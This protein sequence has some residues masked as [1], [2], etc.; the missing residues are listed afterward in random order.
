MET[1][2]HEQFS[3]DYMNRRK[4]CR[5]CCEELEWDAEP[6]GKD[7]CIRYLKIR[8]REQDEKMSNLLR[9]FRVFGAR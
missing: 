9:G 4:W 5:K 6:H 2:D 7:D 3:V 1:L 8:E